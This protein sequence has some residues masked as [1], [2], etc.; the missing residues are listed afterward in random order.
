MQDKGQLISKEL[1]DILK[2]SKK[3][4]KIFDLTTIIP[5]LD[6]FSFVFWKNL[7]TPNRHFEID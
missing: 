5:Q 3:P 7:K 1:F 4:R 2:S 6:L